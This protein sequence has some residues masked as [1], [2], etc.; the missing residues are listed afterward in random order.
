MSRDH[1][2][3]QDAAKPKRA[4]EPAK[5]SLLDDAARGGPTAIKGFDFQRRYALILLLEL[6][7]DPEWRAVLVEGA[8]DVEARFDRQE[9]IER[10]AVQLKNYRVTAAAAREIIDHL[11]K[12]DED[13]PGTWQEFVIA[14]AELDDTLKT[15][16]NSLQ[17]Y[18]PAGRFYTADDAILVNTRADLERQIA[19]ARLPVEFVL[20]RV[21]FEP[22]LQPCNEEKWVHAQRADSAAGSQSDHQP[23]GGRG[24][25]SPPEGSG[26]GIYGPGHRA[27]AG[28]GDHRRSARQLA[29][30]ASPSTIDLAAAEAIYRQQLVAVYGRLSFSGFERGDL[31]LPEVPLEKVFI[32][33]SLTEEKGKQERGAE[34]LGPRA[35][36]RWVRRRREPEQE[37]RAKGQES[38]EKIQT[39]VE[40][41]AALSKNVL[42]VGEP[43]AGK[44]T[45]LRWLAVTFA[46]RRQRE[47]DRLGSQADADLLPV[48]VELGRLPEQYL[49]PD[50]REMPNWLAFLP[51]EIRRQLWLRQVSVDDI[52]P[53]LFQNA[54]SEGRCLLMFDGLDEVAAGAIRRSLAESLSE[55]GRLCPKIRIV[56]ASRPAGVSEAESVLSQFQRCQIKRLTPPEVKAFFGTWYELDAGLPVTDRQAAADHLFEQL[57]ANPGAQSLATTPLLATM[58]LL[59]WRNEGTLPTR[60][61]DLYNRCCKQL[62]ENWEAGH[63]IAYQGVLADLGW[64]RHLRLLAPL[65]YAIHSQGQRTRR[66]QGRS[67]AAAGTSI[68]ARRAVHERG[69]RKLGGGAVPGE[70]GAAFRAAPARGR[71]AIRVS[72][73]DVS[74]VP[75]GEA[76]RGPGGPRICQS[77]HAAPARGVVA[78]SAPADDRTSWVRQG[79][80]RRR[81]DIQADR[82]DPRC[83]SSSKQALAAEQAHAIALAR[84]RSLSAPGPTR[85][86]H[87]VDAGSRIG[88][89]SQRA[90]RDRAGS[91]RSGDI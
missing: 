14:C 81:E 71:R 45:L 63:R 83:L 76:H 25:L 74:G 85:T 29:Q 18:R 7:P 82:C 39:P 41:V 64:E 56:I 89:R 51:E 79:G 52:P 10:R 87:H 75:G 31:S 59:I 26:V 49:K 16:H 27:P 43:G 69:A 35:A 2:A 20:G 54:L 61:V 78:R 67:G 66:R 70:P 58:L 15:I 4:A 8:E 6:L 88:A 65:A 32:R 17:R 30:E 13:S 23:P 84:P 38:V 19:A 91:N 12:L 50:A 3:E 1:G 33:L 21:T 5:A 22:S 36:D 86:T 40:L 77:V 42:I 57:Q 44:S 34:R 73:P 90:G 55:F 48:L 9:R 80:C 28:R 60:R 46:L 47:K 72:S 62:I 37:G 68:A 53:E 11:K 24:D